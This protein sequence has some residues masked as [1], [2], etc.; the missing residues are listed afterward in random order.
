MTA[1]FSLKKIK[2]RQTLGQKLK[3]M[4]SRKKLSLIDAEL[5]TKIRA[6][7]LVALENN[8]WINL[9]A[10]AY[11]KGFVIRYSQFLGLNPSKIYREYQEERRILVNQSDNL[12]MPKKKTHEF[13]FIITP[14]I[15]VPILACLFILFVFGYI[16]YQIMG[17]AAA[18]EL[19]VFSP[20]DNSILDTDSIEI[21]GVT[22]QRASIFINDQAVAVSS[23]GKFVIDYKL[24]KGINTIE[25]KSRNRAEKE[26]ALVY[27]V[28]YKPKTAESVSNTNQN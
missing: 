20:A 9:P 18:P 13:G 7:Y 4:R 15:F 14:K 3:R 28:E 19:L 25:I 27:T 16:I 8:D 23:D 2:S 26:K 6:K 21:R 5:A 24:N 22:D 10:D 12:L 17:F 11:T 1:G